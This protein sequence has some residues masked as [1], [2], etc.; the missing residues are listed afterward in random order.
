MAWAVRMWQIV[1]LLGCGT[2][3]WSFAMPFHLEANPL[4]SQ[5]LRL[6][7]GSDAANTV[8]EAWNKWEKIDTLDNKITKLGEDINDINKR[9]DR[10]NKWEKI[11][12]DNKITKLGEDI[13]DINTKLG[14][15]INDLNTK[16]DK[17]FDRLNAALGWQG[18]L[19]GIAL[20]PALGFLISALHLFK[21]TIPKTKNK[22][23][24]KW[25]HCSCF[26]EPDSD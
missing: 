7:G 3:S 23:K 10:W 2:S 13:N 20:G 19:T 6:R 9:L 22:N 26:G 5:C 1:L 25:Y 18:V 12:L 4:Q 24:K 21:F 17:R 11:K 8:T 14:K 15:D 16:L